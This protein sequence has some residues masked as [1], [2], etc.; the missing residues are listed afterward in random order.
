MHTYLHTLGRLPQAAQRVYARRGSTDVLISL[1]AST[2]LCPDVANHLAVTNNRT[3]RSLALRRATDVDVLVDA[4]DK[5]VHLASVV[6]NPHLP[7]DLL[8]QAL[9]SETDEVALRALTN[10]STRDDDRR[11]VTL[12]R[13]ARLVTNLRG[14]VSSRVVRAHALM[15][16]NPHLREQLGD[17]PGELVRATAGLVDLTGAELEDL[18]R[19]GGTRFVKRHPLLN[20]FT[21]LEAMS[22][23][24]VVRSSSP[25]ADL[26]LA[27]A[28]DTGLDEAR[29][30][31]TA[32]RPKNH[33]VE[34]HVLAL[35][36]RRW[37]L[38]LFCG[39]S[40]P[41]LAGTRVAATVW[42]EPSLHWYDALRTH[43]MSLHV[44][45]EHAS[46]VFGNDEHLWETFLSL[47]KDWHGPLG[48]LVDTVV[49][50]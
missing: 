11:K 9:W 23:T 43:A 37:G 44:D 50:L 24:D 31:L 4:Y 13:S 16:N 15:A 35:M 39:T 36:Y 38:A 3:V 28:P 34:P 32:E 49:R 14:S 47:G 22:A 5:G 25:A 17:L 48:E 46:S 8:E 6:S 19:R 18:T 42:T 26:W 20:G 27:G 1:A 21:S 41:R 7:T 2:G 29:L 30:L 33:H 12:C 45:L 40:L 10:P